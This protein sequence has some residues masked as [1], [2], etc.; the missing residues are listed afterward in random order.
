M[1]RGTDSRYVQYARDHMRYIERNPAIHN[2]WKHPSS[3]L[4]GFELLILGLRTF[5]TFAA[6]RR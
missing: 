6:I 5:F 1:A 4:Y 3:Q 2:E